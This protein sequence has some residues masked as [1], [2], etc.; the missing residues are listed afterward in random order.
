MSV[1][2][3][4]RVRCRYFQIQAI[5]LNYLI[6][7]RILLC[8]QNIYFVVIFYSSCPARALRNPVCVVEIYFI[9]FTP[10]ET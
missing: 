10:N 4:A 6:D 2:F 7:W 9:A 5:L 8:V 3:I 1:F